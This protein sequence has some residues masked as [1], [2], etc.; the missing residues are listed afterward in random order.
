VQEAKAQH[1]LK[2]FENAAFKDS[3]AIDD[4]AVRIGSA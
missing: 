1:L 3:E 2:Q 4:F